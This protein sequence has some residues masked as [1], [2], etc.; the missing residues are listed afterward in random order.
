[1]LHVTDIAGLQSGGASRAPRERPNAEI[2]SASQPVEN[3]SETEVYY[4]SDT[5]L[6][7]LTVWTGRS[8]VSPA[9]LACA[10]ALRTAIRPPDQRVNPPSQLLDE[11]LVLSLQHFLRLE[12][13]PILILCRSQKRTP[14]FCKILAIQ[15]GLPPHTDHVKAG[16]RQYRY[17]SINRRSNS[18]R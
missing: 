7:L 3:P 1:M 6:P 18:S 9:H 8:T 12:L 2:R 17:S 13:P 11:H 4:D 5:C 10:F 16:S 15:S 14:P